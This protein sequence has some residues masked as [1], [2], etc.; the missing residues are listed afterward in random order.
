MIGGRG[1]NE[2]GRREL[3]WRRIFTAS[4]RRGRRHHGVDGTATAAT[5]MRQY[6]STC[7]GG[8]AV[9]D[10]DHLRAMSAARL[11]GSKILMPPAL[12]TN[13]P[14]GLLP[15]QAGLQVGDHMKNWKWCELHRLPLRAVD[16]E[17]RIGPRFYW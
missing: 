11:L 17:L 3:Q 10:R 5:A 16:V 8:W 4:A 1:E 6:L 2:I 7:I 12:F 15:S 14:A 9:G 13:K